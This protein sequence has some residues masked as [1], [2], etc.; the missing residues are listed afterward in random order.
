MLESPDNLQLPGFMTP[1]HP[2]QD[3]RVFS[4]PNGQVFITIADNLPKGTPMPP[5]EI[6]LDV[7]YGR[8]VKL[9]LTAGTGQVTKHDNGDGTERHV[10]WL[11]PPVVIIYPG[12]Y[13]L[14]VLVNNKEVFTRSLLVENHPALP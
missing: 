3:L 11:G 1:G 7:E 12:T 10:L 4:R 14:R 5:Y 8:Y 2:K 13:W 9:H 6:F